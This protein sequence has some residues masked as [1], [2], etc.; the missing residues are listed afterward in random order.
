MLADIISAGLLALNDYIATHVLT[1][2]VPAFFLAGAMV[3]FIRREAVLSLLGEKVNKLRS[4]SLASGSSFLIAACS[5]T[6]IP[7]ASAWTGV[8][9]T[10][11]TCSRPRMTSEGRS[12]SVNFIKYAAIGVM[13]G[14]KSTFFP[15]PA[16]RVPRS[17]F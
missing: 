15:R 3:T 12:S 9:S 7:V 4:F 10:K 16:S 6:V 17:C 8:R 1:C 14:K 5:C 11:P 13:P 2:L